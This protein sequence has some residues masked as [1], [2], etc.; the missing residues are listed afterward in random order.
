MRPLIRIQVT[1]TV[2]AVVIA[3][4]VDAHAAD[5]ETIRSLYASAAYEEALSSL[6]AIPVQERNEHVDEYEALCFL[7]LGRTT[8]AEQAIEHLIRQHPG[9]QVTSQEVSPRLVELFQQVRGRILPAIVKDLYVRAKASYEGK[10]F[11]AARVQFSELITVIAS[12]NQ[13]L[14]PSDLAD[15]RQLAEGFLKLAEAD[16]AA[17]V[18]GP[19]PVA[20]LTSEAGPDGTPVKIYSPSDRDVTPPLDIS[21]PVPRWTP[22][23]GE[24]QGTYRGVLE[25]IID[26]DGRVE[27]ASLDHSILGS[28]DA[29]LLAAAK[30]W[31]FRPA[32]RDGNPVKYQKQIEI[33]LTPAP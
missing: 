4:A 32:T 30:S 16:I 9:Y 24:A 21:R 2:L 14:P 17:A 20:Q 18:P 5:L 12:E 33:V 29:A 7:A 31:R 11:D 15:I 25:V 13:A 22:P 10:Q 1:M 23:P 26:Q 8:D 6:T 3:A 19:P 27:H 28:Y